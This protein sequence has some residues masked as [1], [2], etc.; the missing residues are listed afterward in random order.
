MG[1]CFFHKIHKQET[2]PLIKK[3]MSKLDWEGVRKTRS[4]GGYMPYKNLGNT[5]SNSFFPYISK[6]WNT[7]PSSIQSLDLYDFKLQL[8]LVIKPLKIK[9]KS[10]GSKIGN[11]FLTR[12]RVGRSDLNLHKFTIGQIDKPECMCHFLRGISKTLLFGLLFV[13]C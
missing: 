6:L 5:F 2:R 7:L 13:H 10:M 3:F 12:I 4:R 1:L 11:C 8:K 9:H